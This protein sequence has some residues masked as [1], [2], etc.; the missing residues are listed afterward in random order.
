MKI[1][2]RLR[3][4]GPSGDA[5][6]PGS[7]EASPADADQLPIPG[8]DRLDR[9]QIN[10]LLPQL[11]QIELTAVETY[12]RSHEDRPE[13]L[14]KLR[15]MRASEP[16]PGYDALATEQI[17]EALADADGETVKAVRDYERKFQH[18][19]SVLDEVGRVLPTSKASA[20]EDRARE[21]QKAL[22]REGLAGRDKT[23][24]GLASGR[25]APDGQERQNGFGANG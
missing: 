5:G 3:N 16:L 9:K 25:S 4:H 21:Q 7:V 6:D 13:V 10:T 1:L 18:R 8:Y 24:G 14:D 2:E 12:E 17:A 22:V 20:Q 15:Y 11:S 19:R 23:A